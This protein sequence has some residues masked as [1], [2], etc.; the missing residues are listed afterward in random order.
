MLASIPAS[1]LNPTRAL[2]GIPSDSEKT[3][4]ALVVKLPAECRNPN[5][6]DWDTL[7]RYYSQ[8]ISGDEAAT[9]E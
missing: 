6:C 4:P 2:L 1:I 5:A 9:R 3:N 7:R 8:L